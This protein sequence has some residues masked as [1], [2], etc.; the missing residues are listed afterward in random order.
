MPS[1]T[2]ATSARTRHGSYGHRSLPPIRRIRRVARVARTCEPAPEPEPA[3]ASEFEY[4]ENVDTTD[5]DAVEHVAD[6]DVDDGDDIDDIDDIDAFAELHDNI[7]NNVG[8]NESLRRF[9]VRCP[10][11]SFT[12]D[13][14]N[15]CIL[16]ETQAGPLMHQVRQKM[17]ALWESNDGDV[18]EGVTTGKYDRFFVSSKEP[19]RIGYFPDAPPVW[20]DEIDFSA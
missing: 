19:S 18:S 3:P 8:W 11:E 16:G 12:W 5:T 10:G 15:K 20:L 7:S 14:I 9:L 13:F 6:S 2:R 17:R 4:D 1:L